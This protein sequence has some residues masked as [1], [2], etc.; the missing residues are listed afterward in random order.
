VKRARPSSGVTRPVEGVLVIDKPTGISSYGVIRTV[1][2][3]LS[4]KKI[5]HT[6]TLDPLAS[7]VLPVVI[8]GATKVIPFLD[9]TV[10][11]YEGTL[12]FGMVTDTDDSTGRVIREIR[13]DESVLATDRIWKVFGRFVGKIE[14]VPPMFSAV[15]YHGT[16]L[17]ELARRGIHVERQ[18]K[19]VEIFSL[20]I[21]GVHLPLVDFRVCCSRGTYVR[22]L[23]RQIGDALGV[24]AHLCRL[25]R[26]SSGPF[27]LKQSVTLAELDRLVE[28]GEIDRRIITLR[29]A[30][31][32]MPEI[33]IDDDLGDRIRNGRQVFLG[34]LKGLTMPSLERNQRV[35][36]LNQGVIVAIARAQVSDNDRNSQIPG[37]PAFSLLRVF[38]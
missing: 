31:R 26:T 27:S 34:D 36:I 24:G 35:K 6:G 10:K 2:K 30:L 20:E 7:G 13:L 17:Y 29:E 14:Q 15:K 9:E 19:E 5:G 28:M 33:E 12:R 18:P 32:S 23:S 22:T 21:M 1:K 38:A 25:R 8:N 4:P 3:R 16:P 37:T 11:S